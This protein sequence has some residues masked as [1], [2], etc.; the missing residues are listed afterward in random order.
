MSVL[1][2]NLPHR[3][4][5][6][7]PTLRADAELIPCVDSHVRADGRELRYRADVVLGDSAQVR[8]VGESVDQVER[9]HGQES[10]ERTKLRVMGQRFEALNCVFHA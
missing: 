9:V 10:R 8:H 3:P 6:R 7:P 4:R 1:V 2:E 5:C